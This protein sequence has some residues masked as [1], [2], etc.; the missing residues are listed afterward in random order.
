M[1]GVA[2]VTLVLGFD[3]GAGKVIFD[4]A[5]QDYLVEAHLDQSQKG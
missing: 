5:F 1:Q 2:V 3:F 4:S